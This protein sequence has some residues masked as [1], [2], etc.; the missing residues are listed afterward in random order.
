MSEQPKIDDTFAEAFPMRATRLIITA[1][2]DQLAETAAREFCGNASSVIGCDTEAGIECTLP[3]NETIDG[4]PGVSVL[5]FAFDKKSLEKAVTARV[6]QNVLTCPTT[7]CYSG[8]HCEDKKDRIK[9]GA[10]LRF[11]GDGYQFSKKLQDRRFWRVPVMDGEFLC[12]DVVGTVKGIG[13]G[14]LLVC[15]RS[16]SETLSAVRAAADAINRLP[17][18][19]LPFPSGIVRAGSK[20]GSKYAQL[21]ASTN[22]KW[23]P[24]LR[25][26]TESVLRDDEQ[27]V[28][29]IVIDGLSELAVAAAMLAG[30]NAAASASG[31]LRISAGNYGGKLGPHHFHLHQ[32]E[33]QQ[34]AGA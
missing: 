7:A 3:D 26:Q 32:L 4:R 13:G 28:Y 27:A 1:L 6:G 18:V 5:A 12:E 8:L 14:N 20:V 10:Q 23:C 24:S 2:D 16:L 25:G 21:K 19:I 30:L 11:F 31:V 9:V 29:E 33:A 34:H 17:D 15:G 22:E